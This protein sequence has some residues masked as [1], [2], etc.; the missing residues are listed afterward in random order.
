MSHWREHGGTLTTTS[1]QRVTLTPDEVMWMLNTDA[2][3]NADS[4]QVD[5]AELSSE[6]Y[7]HGMSS[8]NPDGKTMV[9]EAASSV[10]GMSVQMGHEDKSVRRQV[11]HAVDPRAITTVDG[12]RKWL[13]TVTVTE[14][15]GTAWSC[16][17]GL[18]MVWGDAAHAARASAAR[19]VRSGGRKSKC[20]HCGNCRNCTER[21]RIARKR[22]AEAAAPI[23]GHSLGL[24]SV[25]IDA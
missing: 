19:T 7:W 21:E 6:R 24:P 17:Y 16:V 9:L 18:G 1:G 2:D 22:A 3:L 15:D 10:G 12:G 23:T 13:S 20:G 25:H 5:Y 14:P 4:V 11:R 8:A